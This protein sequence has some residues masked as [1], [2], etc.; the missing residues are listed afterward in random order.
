MNSLN[1]YPLININFLIALMV[2][3]LIVIFI[4]FKLKAPGNI[5]RAML[6]CLII[7]SI[8]NPTIISENRENIPDTVAVVLDLSPSQDINNRKDIAQKTYNN[9]KN[10]LE[11]INNLD[12]R[13]KTIN[14]ERGS[15][16][17]EPLNSMIGDVP[18]ERLA[19]AIIIT[20]GQ[21]SDAPTLLDNFNFKSP[22]NVLLTGNKEEKDRRL[23]IESSPRFGIVGEEINID[24]KVEDISASSPN[25][26]VS[27]NMNDEI[28]QS[29]SIPIG[30]IVTIT[31]PLERAGITSLNI[32]VE[33]GKEE[34]TLQ[35]NKA[36]VEINAIRERL[37]VMLV[38]GEPNMGLRS[39][40]NLL[41]SDPSVDLIH[42]TILRPPNKQDLTPVGEL[43]LIPFPSR[44]LFQANLNDFDLIIFDQYHLR[45]ILPQFYLKNVVEYVVNGGAL[46]DASGPSY[47]GP[48][49]LS[50]S[51]LQ[52]I[53]PTEP[54]GDVV[55]QEFIP[56]MT[57]YG[58]RHPVTANLKDNISN[59][60]GPWYRMVEGITI[61]GDVLLEGPEA[62]PLLVLNRVGQ[63]RVAQILSDQ[64]WV[65]TKP[66][67]N[68]GPQADLL[69][70]LVHWL[71]KEPELEENELSARI[72]NNTILI[73]KNSLT[74]DN[75]PII[76]I[77]P[78]NTKKEI[79]LEDIGKGKQIGKI[80]SPQE[81]TWKF[82]S[83]NSKITLIVGNSNASE[84][85]DVRTTD[86]IVEPIVE[87]T[88]GSINWVNNEN[89]PK[90]RHL[91][92]S[93]LVENN[94]HIKLVKNEKYF[95]KSLQQSTLTPWYLILVL[96]LFLLFLAWYRETK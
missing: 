24:I 72:D 86:N 89:L 52:N 32:E 91:P 79:I 55:L 64:S 11:K 2:L 1:F 67:S 68:K 81:G 63:G 56:I 65:W 80:L 94:D 88:S 42:F 7:L 43:S 37:K 16:I 28:E 40:R 77:S 10:E 58:E 27:I 57:N 82:S 85:L 75:K 49:S 95:V 6:L 4:G 76:S 74:L 59:N 25:A 46:L 18:A 90:I 12:V 9:I 36:V 51:P 8:S 66:G 61:A 92:K 83:G 20:D 71:M 31:M 53:L 73:T 45:G 47:A 3:S 69:R 70:R 96:S 44:E 84:Y 39:W 29:R 19:G 78:D 15:K 41:N 50:L 33:A 93:K 13:L 5:F 54:T 21:I 62:R 60:W 30:E 38:S 14:G 17:F 48:Y 34:L 35:N 87:F 26:L 23:I 22:I